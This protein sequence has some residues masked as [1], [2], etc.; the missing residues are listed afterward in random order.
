MEII[1]R[2]DPIKQKQNLSVVNDE[3]N[4]MSMEFDEKEFK[5]L[6]IL[7]SGDNSQHD[8]QIDINAKDTNSQ[9]TANVNEI[10]LNKRG[11]DKEMKYENDKYIPYSPIRGASQLVHDSNVLYQIDEG[12][13]QTRNEVDFK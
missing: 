8:D 3:N 11:N 4:D 6:N 1:D 12:F 13:N 7:K 10:N 2:I 9:Y 5:D